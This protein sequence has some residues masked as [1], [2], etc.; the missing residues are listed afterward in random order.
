[1]THSTQ[2]RQWVQMWKAQCG[3]DANLNTLIP[4]LETRDKDC[5][6]QLKKTFAMS[7]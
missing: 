7:P 5:A 4:I 2:A 6:A 3:E 1:M